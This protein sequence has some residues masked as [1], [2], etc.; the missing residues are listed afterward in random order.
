MA[1]IASNGYQD[2]LSKGAGAVANKAVNYG[3]IR[4]LDIR[5]INYIIKILPA[6]MIS[7][8][9]HYTFHIRMHK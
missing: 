7:G 4:L 5:L 3:N 2:Y 9:I 8:Q 6:S 1:D